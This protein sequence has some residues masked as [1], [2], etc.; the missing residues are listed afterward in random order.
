MPL[1]LNEIGT[2]FDV[3]KRVRSRAKTRAH[4]RASLFPLIGNYPQK[5]S[6]LWI[7]FLISIPIGRRKN[8]ILYRQVVLWKMAYMRTLRSNQAS[9]NRRSSGV[10]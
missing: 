1:Y 8:G 2:K 7:T 3:L 5:Q 4:A 6:G 9:K 10:P